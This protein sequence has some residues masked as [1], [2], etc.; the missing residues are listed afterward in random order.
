MSPR[1]LGLLLAILS[2]ASLVS[3]PSPTAAIYG[4]EVSEA[5]EYP[6]MALLVKDGAAPQIICAGVLVGSTKIVTAASCTEAGPN[7]AVLG[8]TT[9]SEMDG[10]ADDNSEYVSIVDSD[11]HPGFE[12]NEYERNIAVLTLDSPAQAQPVPLAKPSQSALWSDAKSAAI[13]GWG[14][15][16]ASQSDFSDQLHDALLP[17]VSD[18]ECNTTDSPVGC[19]GGR[20][21][22]TCAGDIGGPALVDNSVGTPVLVGILTY[23]TD[24]QCGDGG[25][26]YFM[27]VGQDPIYNWLK[28]QL[29]VLAPRVSTA[30]PTSTGVDRDVNVKAVFSEVMRPG[31]LNTTTFKLFRIDGDGDPRR[32]ENV[33]V[34]PRADGRTATLNP[35]R[36]LAERTRYKA[37]VT[38]GAQDL[39]RLGLDQDRQQAGDQPKTWF[40]KTGAN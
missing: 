16:S 25:L 17:I 22:G 36:R 12:I 7:I 2:L 30:T 18:E 21:S 31:T 34:T 6:A 27:R 39:A 13:A 5:G 40:F 14:Y 23:T 38:T 35:A 26:S 4:G 20:G 15:T 24:S 32:I 28:I 3:F 33:T 9:I 37:V 8:E 10:G 1:R 11:I 19:A 29:D